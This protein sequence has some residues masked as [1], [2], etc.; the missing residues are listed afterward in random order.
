VALPEPNVTKAARAMLESLYNPL[1]DNTND[2][3]D[4][5]IAKRKAEL[6]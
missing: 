5:L 6:N 4:D 2:G 1:H 3:L